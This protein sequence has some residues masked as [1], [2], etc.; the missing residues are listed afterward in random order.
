VT[1][2]SQNGYIANDT[3]CLAW[4]TV[5]GTTV[6]FRLRKGAVT[7]VLTYL[8]SRFDNEVEDIDTAGSFISDAKPSI[9]G[10][11]PS[12][13]L[14]DWSYAPR[15]IRGSTTT[16]SNHASGTAIDLNA[17]QHP[18]GVHGTF[19]TAQIKAVRAI[20]ADL[21][22]PTTGRGIVRWGEDYQTAPVDGMHFEINADQAA[23][24]RVAA[25]I[26]EDDDMALTSDDYDEIAR[27]VWRYTNPKV[28]TR[29]TYGIATNTNGRIQALQ[30]A[31]GQVTAQQAATLAALQGLDAAGIKAAIDD[32]MSSLR[33]VLTA[34]PDEEA[35]S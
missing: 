4:T 33:L 22:D 12:T 6:R 34:Q 23:V 29:D 21:R 19:T 11:E 25:H 28:S 20:L 32:A 3:D 17:T 5:P 7:D 30:E 24:A 18:R 8:A 1:V 9:P 31:M 15:P 14:D 16:L 2:Y 13:L 35:A 27:R 26:Q 10:G